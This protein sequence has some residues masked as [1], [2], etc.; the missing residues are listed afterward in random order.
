MIKTTKLYL[1]GTNLELLIYV[2]RAVHNERHVDC[3]LNKILFLLHLQ[4][5][6][7]EDRSR[8]KCNQKINFSQVKLGTRQKN[9]SEAKA[10]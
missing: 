8:K 4:V 9:V 6:S 10:V 2:Y 3:I 1:T 7:S 5:L